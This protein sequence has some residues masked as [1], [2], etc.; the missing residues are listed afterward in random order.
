MN[1]D[2]FRTIVFLLLVAFS[3]HAV[4]VSWI[5]IPSSQ[6]QG[7]IDAEVT[8]LPGNF[9]AAVALPADDAKSLVA[10]TAEDQMA[11][12]Y[13]VRLTVRSSHVADAIAFYSSLQLVQGSEI[14]ADWPGYSFARTHQSEIRTCRF[15]L[16]ESGPLIV[17]LRATADADI[18]EQA[19][20]AANLK[21]GGPKLSA[22]TDG[23]LTS[24]SDGDLG[25]DFDLELILSPDKA[26]YY[27][28]DKIE[29]RPLSHSGHVTA[30]DVDKIRYLPGEILKG[31]VTVE[32]TGGKG[33]TGTLNIY[34]EHNLQD[35]VL[36][37][38]LPATLKPQ[39]QTI[40]FEIPL[41]AE[42]L[43][44]ALIAQFVSDDGADRSEKAE[45]FS[46]AKNFQRVAIFGG[47][48][49]TRDVVLTE[50]DEPQ[51]RAKLALTRSAYFNAVEYFAWA[52]DDMVEMS[53][54]TNFWSSGQTNYRMHKKTIQRQIRLAHEQGVAV[55]TY[56]KFCMSGLPGWKT[57]YDY[58]YDHRGQYNYPVGMWPFVNVP[59]L[60]RRRDRDFTVYG[61]MPK[62]PGNA[63]RTWWSDFMPINPDATPRMTRVAAEECIRSIDIFGWDA[64]RWDGHVRAAGWVQCGRSGKYQAWAARQTQSLTRYFKD[65]VAEKYPEFRHGYNYLLIEKEKG[66]D[67]AVE[68]YELDEL[69]RD[70]GLIMNE[71][72][73]NA[74]AG[75]TFAQVAQNLQ[76]DGDLCRERGGYY[77]GI[78]FA[79]RNPPRDI[80]IESALWAAAGCRPYNDSM[81]RE[82][83]RYCTRYSQYTFDEGLRRLKMPEKILTPMNETRLW[84]Q[85]FVYETPLKNG[86]R[87]LVVNLLNLP[88]TDKRPP[89]E[90]TIKP[91]YDMPDGTDPVEF[92][93]T[94]PEGI[95]ATAVHL[96][97]P[98]TLAVTDVPLEENQFTVPAISTWQVAI[99]DLDVKK[100]A[101]SLASLYGTPPT[102][103]VTRQGVDDTDRKPDVVLD[104]TVALWEVNKRI[105][106]LVPESQSKA[107]AGQAEL[108]RLS[109]E[110]RTAALLARRPDP[111][112][113]AKQ[114]WKG[115]SI[116]ADIKLKDSLPTFGDLT[117]VRNGTLDIFYAHG[118]M[119][120]RL[121]MMAA[122][123]GLD[124][125][126][127]HHA[128][129]VGTVR[130][131]PAMWLANGVPGNR[132]PEFDLL[133]F[134][135]IPH[136]AIGVKNAYALVDY[137]KA[138]GGV[139]FTGG[140]YSFGKGGYIHTV[141]EREL[142]PVKMTAMKDTVYVDP[143]QAF[144]P[145]PDFKDL[146]VSLDF[147]TKPV[148][149]VR[150]EVVLKPDVKIFLQSGGRPILVGWQLGKGRVVCL[151]VDHRGKSED[152]L[153]AFFDWKDWPKLMAATIRWAA[154]GAGEGHPVVV[155]TSTEEP[156][157]ATELDIL[158]DDTITDSTG[159]R[160]LP[161]METPKTPAEQ[162]AE[163]R[164][165]VIEMLLIT[166]DERVA[167]GR[168]KVAKWNRQEADARAAFAKKIEPDT[169]MLE[170][171]PFLDADAI[172]E[173]CA[174]L[175][176]L[177]RYE[178]QT[179]GNAFLRE[180]LLIDQYRDYC[181]RTRSYRID[182]ESLVGARA[183]AV[184]EFWSDLENCF[185]TLQ[186]GA[187]R[188][189]SHVL[190][191]APIEAGRA[192]SGVRFTSE[193]RAV[194][195]LLGNMGYKE[196]SQILKA[197][198]N[199]NDPDLAAFARARLT[200]I[201]H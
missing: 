71:S 69:C 103:G 93:V 84:W 169:A 116:P 28:V 35:R 72:I 184:Y 151:L 174:W 12:L 179:Y 27:L 2:R 173:R 124:R 122:F 62:V 79:S 158:F 125:F 157:V 117:P 82:V 100:D 53:P 119:D 52:P 177:S 95:S 163:R 181:R 165:E 108:D 144:E 26:V 105:E 191:S 139:I 154:P 192:M 104:P 87:H 68:D 193:R 17:D 130:Q 145:G 63:F 200:E 85:P 164:E 40:S 67:W 36:A 178:P 7:V 137:V 77:L 143:R 65:I 94:L 30:I 126:K 61:K 38:S 8:A 91:T 109:C 141:L 142:L 156:S 107:A 199:S 115:A 96:I 102:L 88:Q 80:V 14:V 73:G 186:K 97:D 201:S 10:T 175:A 152:G 58:P 86:R 11:G 189:V 132:Y 90:G 149:W 138:G 187:A 81:S 5:E 136:C 64:I 195:N 134:T 172:F 78:S 13:E 60:D 135:G 45:Y 147:E 50:A 194:I 131:S 49:G 196:S 6:W 18:T 54:D 44:Y 83:R 111:E 24:E 21:Q 32:D 37:L 140:E 185:T 51:I 128:G 47:G 160:D 120:Y 170:T 167:E 43:G 162:T 57:A 25:F 182:Q 41:P 92:S 55:S 9:A 190:A 89:R 19:W 161:T 20:V 146:G 56:G 197:V 48:L 42:E 76:V 31:H 121:R 133:L 168:T 4:S 3:A 101:P 155:N 183:K 129:L 148:F 188:D 39:P 127:I 75:W 66:Y 106:E 166:T 22:S 34:L 150:N 118:A 29:Y 98:T 33:G 1:M 198:A 59:L 171:S 23:L 113:L 15:V 123:A 16:P 46:I 176:Y 180:W 159:D 70:G 153:T 114:W 74:S 99:I 112:E 110:T